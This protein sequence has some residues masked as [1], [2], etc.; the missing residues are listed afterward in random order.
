MEPEPL[1]FVQ[2]LG[3]PQ[4]WQILRELAVSDRKV[5]ELTERLRRPQS[6]VSYHLREL[7]SAGL[8]SA[9]PSSADRRDTYYRIEFD[10]CAELWCAAGNALQPGLRLAVVP[11]A[12]PEHLRAARVLFLSTGNS[13]RSQIAEAMLRSYTD[14]RLRVYSAGSH[15]K[16]LHPTALHVMATRGIDIS[17][18][19]SKD[20]RLFAARRFDY[21]ITLCDRVR[22]ICPEFPGGP[23]AMH[24]S[25][26][27]P[28]VEADGDA[29]I[30]AAFE[31]TADEIDQRVRVLISQ[32]TDQP[33]EVPA[34]GPR[35][36]QRPLSR[37]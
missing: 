8:V 1:H 22:E 6:L 28:A 3:D 2:V 34:R 11:S 10:R 24:W 30:E 7:R 36:R 4:R 32:L 21:V 23:S 26:A 13:A 37:R 9:K 16:P 12:T 17:E 33:E 14:G 18:Q 35:N 19:V 5:S 29:A 15:P 31:R 27:D 25:V 20:L